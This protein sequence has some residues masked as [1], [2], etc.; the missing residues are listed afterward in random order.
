[1]DVC[2]EFEKNPDYNPLTNRKI[3]KTGAIY[4]ELVRSCKELKDRRILQNL[5]KI[6]QLNQRYV[7]SFNDH[8]YNR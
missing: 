3:S 6:N 5:H 7:I 8:L 4:T 1:M 2:E